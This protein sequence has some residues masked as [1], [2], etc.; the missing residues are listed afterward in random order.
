M[1]LI[2]RPQ[3]AGTL[4]D[5]K[6]QIEMQGQ[7]LSIGRGAE[8]DVVLPDP[9]RELSK[10]HCVLEQRNGDYVIRDTSTNGTFLNYGAEQLD[11]RP[12]PLNSGD[13]ILVGSFELVVEINDDMSDTHQTSPLLPAAPATMSAGHAHITHTIGSIDDMANTGADFLDELLGDSADQAQAEPALDSFLSPDAPFDPFAQSSSQGLSD[14][15]SAPNHTPS[16]QDHFAAPQSKA[17][18]IPDDW[19]GSFI[20]QDKKTTAPQSTT[21]PLES[22][23]VAPKIQATP[24]PEQISN[25]VALRAFLTGAGADHITIPSAEIEETMARMGK[26]MAAMIDGMRDI[27]MTRAAIKSEMRMDRT[28][29]N[30][31][32]NN[33]LKFSISAEQ[34]IEAMIRPSVPGYIDADDAINEALNDV[35]AHEVA[36][37]SGMEAALKDLLNR[38]NPNQLSTR[39][40]AGL[41]LGGLLANKKARYWES[42]EKMYAQIAQETEDD[43]QSTFGKEF[44]RAYEEQV[45]K[46]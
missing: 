10:R 19:A 35:K 8:N 30:A 42:Y 7:T 39:I 9:D 29:I 43:F 1:P 26:V 36:T 14:G 5:G 3:N 21:P 33:P 4:P 44:A 22:P 38:L 12:T 23:T 31:G 6:A 24:T 27:L 40:E 46:L 34:A 37:M 11:D 17:H 13:V 20:H 2:I 18:L 25:D 28:M 16:A 32:R 41:T 45:K 15:S